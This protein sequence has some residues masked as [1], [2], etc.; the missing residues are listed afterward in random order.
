MRHWRIRLSED[1]EVGHL[2]LTAAG[3]RKRSPDSGRDEPLLRLGTALALH[4]QQ[5]LGMVPGRG[6]YG[7]VGHPVGVVENRLELADGVLLGHQLGPVGVRHEALRPVKILLDRRGAIAEHV[8]HDL[9]TLLGDLFAGRGDGPLGQRHSQ[10]TQAGAQNR[11]CT[12]AGHQP[13]GQLPS[14]LEALVGNRL[15]RLRRVVHLGAG[16]DVGECPATRIPQRPE[17]TGQKR[18]RVEDVRH[19]PQQQSPRIVGQSVVAHDLQ[20]EQRPTHAPPG[21]HR[22][23]QAVGGDRQE[24]HR[25]DQRADPPQPAVHPCGPGD[26]HEND[27]HSKTQEY[28][29]RERTGTRRPIGGRGQ[30]S[31]QRVLG[32][33]RGIL[34]RRILGLGVD[35]DVRHWLT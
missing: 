33:Q 3:L 25:G 31:L 13:G 1:R 28:V 23:H 20:P 8:W 17:P 18:D 34:S 32:D 30:R 35:E 21:D 9:G 11:E 7:A 24:E 19:V 2:P 14:V 4:Q 26:E 5:H 16:E 22:Q 29:D 15:T 6:E 10:H 12:Q 27:E